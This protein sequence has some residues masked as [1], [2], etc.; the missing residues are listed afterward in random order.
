LNQSSYYPG[1]EIDGVIVLHIQSPIKLLKIGVEWKGEEFV[2]WWQ[3]VSQNENV[4]RTRVIFE[5]STVVNNE[6]QELEKGNFSFD[7]NWVLPKNLPG[8]YEEKTSSVS[9][10]SHVFIPDKGLMPKSFGDEKSYIRYYATAFV[11]YEN[12]LEGGEPI[13]LERTSPFRVV[14]EFDPES[15]SKAPVEEDIIEKPFFLFGSTVRVR[16]K[17]ANGSTLFT[18]QNLFL[19]VFVENKSNRKVGSISATVFQTIKF[20][21]TDANND[22]QELLRREPVLRAVFEQS[23]ING[24]GVFDKVVSFQIPPTIPGTIRHSQ[25]IRRTYEISIDVDMPLVTVISTKSPLILLDWSPVL[26]GEVPEEVK[27]NLQ[28]NNPEPTQDDDSLD[29]DDI[30]VETDESKSDDSKSDK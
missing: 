24:A 5:E 29:V 17:I 9:L 7:T 18:G 3:G 4:S 23:E 19:H 1:K 30:S 14:E 2:S 10:L 16:V 25:F 28:S 8:N 12:P 15:L 22:A 21:T 20:A 13:R 26:K 11:E 6:S 27:I